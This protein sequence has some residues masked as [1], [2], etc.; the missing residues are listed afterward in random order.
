MTEHQPTR[1]HVPGE[2]PVGLRTVGAI[3]LVAQLV[4]VACLFASFWVDGLTHVVW[5]SGIVTFV[6]LIGVIVLIRIRAQ[7]LRA[8]ED[9]IADGDEPRSGPDSTHP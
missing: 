3:Y 8:V 2:S 9:R 5:A 7:Y 1:E 6:S 4:F